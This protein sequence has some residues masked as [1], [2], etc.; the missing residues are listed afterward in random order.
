MK[1]SGRFSALLTAALICCTAAPLSVSAVRRKTDS[2]LP[3]ITQ[4]Q[5]ETT[6]AP[7]KTS[8][9][10]SC[11]VDE[12]IAI[13]G[14]KE[15]QYTVKNNILSYRCKSMGKEAV[16]CC[17]FYNGVLAFSLTGIIKTD[18]PDSEL[19]SVFDSIVNSYSA[20]LGEP[21]ISYE[22][23][24]GGV[25]KAGEN[26]VI[27]AY[28]GDAVVTMNMSKSYMNELIEGNTVMPALWN[29]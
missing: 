13:K 22:N 5:T 11:T 2:A 18:L 24:Q 6:Y 1:L 28:P 29:P 19:Q 10:Y 9:D 20:S 14:L 17:Y 21:T 27:A 4:E 12:V 8:I 23:I 7:Q 25:W 26:Y 3:E 15:N 16:T